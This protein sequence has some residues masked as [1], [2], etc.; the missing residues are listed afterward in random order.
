MKYSDFV[1]ESEIKHNTI[2]YDLLTPKPLKSGEVKHDKIKIDFPISFLFWVNRGF[3][4][5]W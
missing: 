2:S 5:G 4:L 3:D 1:H